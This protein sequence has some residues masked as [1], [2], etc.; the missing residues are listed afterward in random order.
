MLRSRLLDYEE[1]HPNC[2][3]QDIID[4]MA[5]HDPRDVAAQTLLP[6]AAEVALIDAEEND[7]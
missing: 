6:A 3:V 4:H 5:L 2:A 1:I 7:A